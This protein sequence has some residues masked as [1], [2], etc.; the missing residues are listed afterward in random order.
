MTTRAIFL[1]EKAF[2]DC[3]PE[4]ADYE[5]IVKAYELDGDEDDLRDGLSRFTSCDDEEIEWHADHRGERMPQAYM[6]G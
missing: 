1:D 3:E 6:S 5:A 2:A 4:A